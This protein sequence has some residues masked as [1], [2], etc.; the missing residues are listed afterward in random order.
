MLDQKGPVVK[1]VSPFEDAVLTSNFTEV[2]W[3]VN[4][5]EQDTLRVQGL[6]NGVQTII[7]VFRDKAG[8]ES[9]DS[10]HVMVKK[11]KNIDITVEKPVTLV[12]RDSVEK[13][14]KSNPPKT[15]ERFSV[16]FFNNATKAE[17]EVL[18]GIKGDVK[19]G[20][21]DEPYP[22]FGGS[23]LGPTL[24]VDARVPV[25]NALGGLATLDDIVS[26][27]GMIAL[28]GVDAANSEKISVDEY[29]EKYCTEEFK[30]SMSSDYSR[31]NLYW[32]TLSV[33]IWV[34][35]NTG[36]FI[37]H[38]SYDYDLSDPDYV[39]EAG[40]LKQFFELKPDENGDVRN[41]DG[42]LYGTGAYLFKTEVKISSKLRCTLPPI[43][44]DRADL[45]KN[46][47]IKSS[48]E[49][50]TSFGYRRPVNK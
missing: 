11:A 28:E 31:V 50:L 9:R 1:I 16:S 48:D 46:A 7:R 23:H 34:F 6:E 29:V 22:G 41:E 32:T 5:V 4:G 30:N 17:N 12:D 13:Y 27:G 47:V 38:Y 2:K 40:L 39:S 15:D 8:N 24:V 20:S 43:S 10:V 3:T 42:R 49:L 21:G 35:T 26:N 19:K 33:K 25:V 44:D 18:V 36:S 14:Y 37:D 45:K